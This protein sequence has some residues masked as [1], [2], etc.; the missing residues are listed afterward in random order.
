[1]HMSLSILS[2]ISVFILY[3]CSPCYPQLYNNASYNESFACE[4]KDLVRNYMLFYEYT[5]N[6][7]NKI[8]VYSSKW[9]CEILR[10]N[11][12]VSFNNYK[13][14]S[15][16][17]LDYIKIEMSLIDDLYQDIDNDFQGDN[18]YYNLHDVLRDRKAQCLGYSQLFLIIGRS[19]GLNVCPIMVLKGSNNEL[20]EDSPGHISCL[21]TLLNNQ[22]IFVDNAWSYKSK[23]F[24]LDDVYAYNNNIYKL[25]QGNNSYDYKEFKYINMFILKSDLYYNNASKLLRENRYV[26]AISEYNKC[27]SIN[28][29]DKK[30]LLGRGIALYETNNHKYSI[31]DLLK[32]IELDNNN[33][34]AY[35]TLGENYICMSKYPEA[36]RYLTKSIDI[37]NQSSFAFAERG[38]AYYMNNEYEKAL[39]DL[40]KSININPNDDLTY[41]VRGNTLY[42]MKKYKEASDDYK[43]SIEINPSNKEYVEKIEGK[44]R[45]KCGE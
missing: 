13:N 38:K 45:K 19:I 32:V 10:S 37:N 9:N 11:L 41:L 6:D 23:P 31:E 1:M 2:L 43:K 44:G 14:K 8:L 21:V 5:T 20:D 34:I 22:I 25:R 24:I 4:Y 35:Y 29:K 7:V 36:V 12:F 15:I 39:F 33:D 40:T 28:G 18:S 17:Q 26:D 3:L 30:A 16:S 42:K 27:I